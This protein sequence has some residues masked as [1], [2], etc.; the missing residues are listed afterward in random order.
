[1]P[2]NNSAFGL[3]IGGSEPQRPPRRVP[4]SRE[5]R[6]Q[7]QDGFLVE[8]KSPDEKPGL[9]QYASGQ[10]ALHVRNGRVHC[11]RKPDDVTV[12]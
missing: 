12:T 2:W 9:N 8:V 7:R 4:I 5:R 11:Y 3:L 1:M 6:R 10:Y